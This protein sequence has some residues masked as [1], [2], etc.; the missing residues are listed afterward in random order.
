VA[1]QRG[2]ARGTGLGLALV[3]EHLRAIGAT[4]HVSS[5]PEGGA[6]FEIVMPLVEDRS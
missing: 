2:A 4:I 1:H 3:R 6:R 5:S